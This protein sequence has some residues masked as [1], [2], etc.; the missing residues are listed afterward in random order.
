M[1]ITFK[2]QILNNESFLKCSKFKESGKSGKR[3]KFQITINLELFGLK[4]QKLDIIVIFKAQIIAT[5]QFRRKKLK[6]KKMQK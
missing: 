3:I 2:I 4:L 1:V 6:C 5:E